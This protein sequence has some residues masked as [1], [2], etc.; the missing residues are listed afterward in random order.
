MF[1]GK[2]AKT[3]PPLPGIVNIYREQLI[4]LFNET[5]SMELFNEF[6]VFDLFTKGQ[7]TRVESKFRSKN[8]W[9]GKLRILPGKF[10]A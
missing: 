10:S 6:I 2:S 3:H 1:P 4:S 8:E 7:K 9:E 5:P